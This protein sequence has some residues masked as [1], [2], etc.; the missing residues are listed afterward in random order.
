MSGE[1]EIVITGMGVVSPIGIGSD[2][3]WQS[4]VSATSGI[5]P[6]DLFDAS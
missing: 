6:V 1:R 2:A 5:R 3:F 4:L